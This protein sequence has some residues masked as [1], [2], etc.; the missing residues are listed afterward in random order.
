MVRSKSY[1][2]FLP[3]FNDLIVRGRLRQTWSSALNDAEAQ[4]RAFLTSPASEWKRIS[5]SVDGS[6]KKGKS[7]TSS[8]P[9]LGDVIV[10]RNSSKAGDDIY[11][12]ILDVPTGDEFVSLEPWKAVL[13][14]PELRQEWDPAVEEAHLLELFDRTTRICKT[15]F[16]LGWP[17]K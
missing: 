2:L 14:T 11:R 13:T 16:T 17:A 8:V 5:S 1:W 12:L 15:N 3:D 7:R 10:H 6:P 9:E 4:F